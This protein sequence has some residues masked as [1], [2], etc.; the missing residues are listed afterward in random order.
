MD[1]M[2]KVLALFGMGIGA[3]MVYKMY[4]PECIHDMKASLDKL[5]KS[6]SKK[7]KNMMQ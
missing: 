5:T 3:F 4:N 1:N 7:M 6:A 2:W